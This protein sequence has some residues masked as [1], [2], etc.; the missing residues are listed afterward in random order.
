MHHGA[1]KT[2]GAAPTK[3]R[4]RACSSFHSTTRQDRFCYRDL[5]TPK[6]QE[7]HLHL[8]WHNGSI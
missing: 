3:E 8:D 7:L 6:H 2:K 5:L 4:V 1:G